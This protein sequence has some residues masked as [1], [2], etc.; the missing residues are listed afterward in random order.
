MPK[1]GFLVHFILRMVMCFVYFVASVFFFNMRE[2]KQKC[3]VRHTYRTELASAIVSNPF[4]TSTQVWRN[5]PNSPNE[6]GD[7]GHGYDQQLHSDAGV[8]PVHIARPLIHAAF[9]PYIWVPKTDNAGEHSVLGARTLL[10]GDR[11]FSEKDVPGLEDGPNTTLPAQSSNYDGYHEQGGT[12]ANV[13]RCVQRAR[14]SDS[15]YTD[16][17][18]KYMASSMHRGVC[19]LSGQQQKVDVLAS[20]S[21]SLTP[22]SSMSMYYIPAVVYF[23]AASFQVMQIPVTDFKLNVPRLGVVNMRTKMEWIKVGVAV[24]MNLGGIGVSIYWAADQGASPIPLNNL[25]IAIVMFSAAALY[26]VSHREFKFAERFRSPRFEK[27]KPNDPSQKYGYY[28]PNSPENTQPAVE[29]FYKRAPKAGPPEGG[30]QMS[31]PMEPWNEDESDHWY[32]DYYSMFKFNVF[33]STEFII[34]TPLLFTFLILVYSAD[35]VPIAI[36]QLLFVSVFV[37][38]GIVAALYT[39][40]RAFFLAP[41]EKER[42]KGRLLQIITILMMVMLIMT[43]VNIWVIVSYVQSLHGVVIATMIM[44]V[45]FVLLAGLNTLGFFVDFGYRISAPRYPFFT[46]MIDFVFKAV[47]FIL[48]YIVLTNDEKLLPYYACGIWYA[49]ISE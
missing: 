32:V 9:I 38:R 3:L 30:I 6:L 15:T 49:P 18:H 35:T 39:M 4:F 23:I 8:F 14:G 19:A 10:L 41:D 1:K 11:Q 13:H 33:S 24:A 20:P 29:E 16:E 21:T 47:V 25:V 48:F 31:G 34:T 46:T 7:G 43:G 36:L 27:Y 40:E 12:F 42:G 2:S 45:L 26:C 5:P 28:N 44:E 22:F 17:L 37:I